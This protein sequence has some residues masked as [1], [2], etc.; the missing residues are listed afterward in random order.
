MEAEAE[1]EVEVEATEAT[2]EEAETGREESGVTGGRAERAAPDDP[3]A[4]AAATPEL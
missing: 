1:A 2:E 4:T 3:A